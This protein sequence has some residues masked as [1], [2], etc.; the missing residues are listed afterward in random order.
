MSLTRP[1]PADLPLRPQSELRGPV[2]PPSTPSRWIIL[3]AAAVI[4][5]SAVGWWWLSRAQP[6]AAPPPP[7]TTTDVTLPSARPKRQPIDLPP[8]DESDQV[9]RRLVAALSANP[10]LARLLATSGLARAATLTVVQIGQ[11]RTP[12]LPLAAVR[13]S[14]R[15]AILGSGGGRIDPQSFHRWDSATNA[16][17]SVRPD[18]LAQV[19]VDVKPLIDQ[20]Y[21]DLGYQDGDFDQAI[22]RAV[23]VLRETPD[24]LAEPV[25]LPRAGYFEFDDPALRALEPVQKQLLLLGPEN[26]RRVMTWIDGLMK[27]L[28]LKAGPPAP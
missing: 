7:T 21:R 5:A 23:S 17:V 22:V 27:T 10:L 24:L 19:Y 18:D 26:R 9:L 16:L 15:L 8:L 4:A 1:D 11:G 3:G 20:A 25:L 12:A 14:T 13:P 2:P 28:D 6:I